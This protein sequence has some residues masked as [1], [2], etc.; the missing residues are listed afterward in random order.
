MQIQCKHLSDKANKMCGVL[1]KPGYF[2]FSGAVAYLQLHQIFL[3]LID[4]F[5]VTNE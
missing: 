1:F 3:D 4:N 5:R 2:M